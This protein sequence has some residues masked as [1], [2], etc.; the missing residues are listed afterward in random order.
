MLLPDAGSDIEKIEIDSQK[1]PAIERNFQYGEMKLRLTE[2]L[3]DGSRNIFCSVSL[4]NGLCGFITNVFL[5]YLK[6][7]TNNMQVR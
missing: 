1:F 5:K 2:S 3:S 6:T 7:I 4:T